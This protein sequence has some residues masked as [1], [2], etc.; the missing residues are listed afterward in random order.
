[1]NVRHV[2]K[3]STLTTEDLT[4]IDKHY[5]QTYAKERHSYLNRIPPK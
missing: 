5:L 1:M 3:N 4:Q 2:L